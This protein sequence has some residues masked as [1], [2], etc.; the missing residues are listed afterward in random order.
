MYADVSRSLDEGYRAV[1]TELLHAELLRT[2][3]A[4]HAAS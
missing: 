4:S 2:F 3:Q 1:A